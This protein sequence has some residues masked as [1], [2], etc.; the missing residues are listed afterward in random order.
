M[1]VAQGAGIP[2]SLDANN[3]EGSRQRFHTYLHDHVDVLSAA[4]TDIAAAGPA[5]VDKGPQVDQVLVAT[6]SMRRDA[7]AAAFSE[8]D[9]V[10]RNQRDT[11]MY[12]LTG[13]TSLLVRPM[14]GPC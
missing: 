3:L 9:S 4:L 7:L 2:P 10:P 14:A 8:L 6:L 1:P 13:V 11:L 12:T 5:P